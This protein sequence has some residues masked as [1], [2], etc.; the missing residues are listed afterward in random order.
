[1]RLCILISLISL[2]G[3]DA[4]K[5]REVLVEIQ[6]VIDQ[7]L[8]QPCSIS[9]RKVATANEL[10]LLAMEHLG[11]ARCANAKITAISETLRD[12]SPTE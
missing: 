9:S 7:E 8:L 1:M 3:C 12:L 11:A 2:T 6:P 10:A 5:P 4:F